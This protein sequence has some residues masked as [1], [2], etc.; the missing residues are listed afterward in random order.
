MGLSKQSFIF[1][2]FRVIRGSWSE[3]QEVQAR[4]AGEVGIEGDE[5]AAAGDGEG[6]EVGIRPQPVGKRG[7]GGVVGE[8]LVDRRGFLEKATVGIGQKL[9][10]EFPCFRV[11]ESAAEDA[12]L[13]AEAEES[14]HGN[15]GKA[16]LGIGDVFPIV[17]SG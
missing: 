5:A 9:A 12:W 10:I 1:F 4:E 13:S 11:G 6:G 3:V 8:V 14:H 15:A 16:D 2:D 7:L 17:R